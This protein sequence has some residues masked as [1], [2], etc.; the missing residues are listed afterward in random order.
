MKRDSSI[1]TVFLISSLG[2]IIVPPM[3]EYIVSQRPLQV[4]QRQN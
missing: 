1:W 4:L 2:S 3:I